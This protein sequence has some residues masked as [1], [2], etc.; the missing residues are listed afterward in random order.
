MDKTKSL[1]FV[2]VI[3]IPSKTAKFREFEGF[4]VKTQQ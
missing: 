1:K 4:Q 2:K 3:L